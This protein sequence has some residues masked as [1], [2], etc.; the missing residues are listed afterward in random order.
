FIVR[1]QLEDEQVDA[2]LKKTEDYVTRNG[3]EVVR[4]EKKGKK[5]LAYECKDQRDGHYLLLNFTLDP[6]GIT[7]LERFFR[8]TDEIVRHLV[9]RQDEAGPVLPKPSAAPVVAA[10]P[11]EA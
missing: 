9:L 8:L 4:S 1:P 5:R 6:T 2:V 11:V 7:E 10:A 3:G